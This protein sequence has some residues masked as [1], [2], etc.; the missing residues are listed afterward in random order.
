MGAMIS[1]GFKLPSKNILISIGPH[2]QKM[3]FLPYARMLTDLG[4]QLYSTKSTAEFLKSHDGFDA[5]ITV[6][7]PLVRR[8]PNVS[9]MLRGGKLDLVINVPDSMDSQAA[10]DGFEMRRAA[11]DSGTSLIVDIKTAVAFT[12]SVHR[13]ITREKS[14][15]SFWSFKSWQEYVDM[16]TPDLGRD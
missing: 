4:F 1:A 6:F 10:S 2:Q 9:T 7:K 5:C 14:G 8:E 16:S 13:K 11:V 15:R 12:M 3:E